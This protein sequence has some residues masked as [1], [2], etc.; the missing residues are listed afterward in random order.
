MLKDRIASDIHQYSMFHPEK[1]LGKGGFA[2]AYLCKS[3][4]IGD[5]K[6]YVL[7]I[8]GSKQ[9]K[10]YRDNE[11]QAN[12]KLRGISE[13]AELIES[14]KMEGNLVLVNECII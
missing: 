6:N 1:L 5:N 2:S 12:I 7:K 4:I 14:F 8:I 11:I 10:K 9:D 3:T 13:V